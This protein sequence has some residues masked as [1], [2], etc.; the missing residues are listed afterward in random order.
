VDVDVVVVV[1]L[2]V[3]VAVVMPVAV[4]VDVAVD[5]VQTERARTLGPP[6]PRLAVL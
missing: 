2:A 4:V 1:S 5:V 6:S 3:V